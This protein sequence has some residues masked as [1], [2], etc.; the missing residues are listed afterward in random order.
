MTSTKSTKIV[1]IVLLTLGVISGLH[2][3]VF[4]SRANDYKAA[5]SQ[6]ES[7]RNELVGLGKPK[8]WQEIYR[9]E[10]QSIDHEIRFLEILRDGKLEYSAPFTTITTSVEEERREK[11]KQLTL[12]WDMMREVQEMGR[13][14]G[15]TR[16][17]FL[18]NPQSWALLT[19]FPE[20]VT[21]GG[22]AVADLVAGLQ[23][24]DAVLK[25]VPENTPLYAQQLNVYQRLLWGIGLNLQDRAR[26]KESLGE[27]PA[28]FYTLNRIDLVKRQVPRE[29]LGGLRT[30]ADYNRRMWDL[31]RLEWED[32]ILYDA[33]KQMSALKEILEV[34]Q[35]R[36]LDEVM[37]VKLWQSRDIQWPPPELE[38]KSA[39]GAGAG[40]GAG[41]GMGGMFMD[42]A[43]IGMNPAMMGMEDMGMMDPYMMDMFGMGMGMGAG[44][45]PETPKDVVAVAVPI[46][47]QVRGS[48]SAVMSFLYELAHTPRTYALDAVELV[49]LPQQENTVGAR[50]VVKVL[51][52]FKPFESIEAGEM[53]PPLQEIENKLLVL[54]NHKKELAGRPG[55]DELA[56]QDGFIDRMGD[57]PPLPPELRPTPAPMAMDPT[58]GMF[59]PSLG[60]MAF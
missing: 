7:I 10:Y 3:L 57:I 40:A 33:Y 46:E 15:R 39:A 1:V 6:Y 14:P 27:L 52:Y 59:D 42:D 37:R 50:V 53:T 2:F 28:I 45:A 13:R 4:R 30:D 17:T 24:A 9:F 31:F 60:G 22:T 35:R 32:V 21:A 56:R 44:A 8:S 41:F 38:D 55:V 47:M 26:I 34:A 58:G 11:E 23:S 18:E 29:D 48:N 51:S 43:M 49:A 19:E 16:F 36:E 12:L 5:R 54:L 25:Q 20:R